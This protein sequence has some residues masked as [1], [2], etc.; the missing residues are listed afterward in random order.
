MK[1]E[2]DKAY[3]MFLRYLDQDPPTRSILALMKE[4]GMVSPS[5]K[6][7]NNTVYRWSRENKWIERAKEYDAHAGKFALDMIFDQRR[8]LATNFVKI[9]D[10][11]I[12][13]AVR[14]LKKIVE[15]PAEIEKLTTNDIITF[16]KLGYELQTSATDMMLE[17]SALRGDLPMILDKLEKIKELQESKGHRVSSG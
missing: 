7:R 15:D 17:D 14:R 1:G 10:A 5:G 12:S 2:T 13:A 9:G 6:Q 4:D 16:I 3:A 8:D 11:L